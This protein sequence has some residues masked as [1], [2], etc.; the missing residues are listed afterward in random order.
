VCV[1][2]VSVC[3]ELNVDNGTISPT[4]PQQVGSRANVICDDGFRIA[5]SDSNNYIS[6]QLRCEEN[7]NWTG[8]VACE[9]KGKCFV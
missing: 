4:G 8:T 5:G 6:K 1:W 7:G 9:S 3:A 2:R